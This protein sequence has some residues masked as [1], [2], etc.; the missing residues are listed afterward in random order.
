MSKKK[1]ELKYFGTAL[2]CARRHVAK[3]S[4]R[5]LEQ[6]FGISRKQIRKIERGCHMPSPEFL[7][8]IFAAGLSKLAGKQD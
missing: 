5:E 4:F 6:I 3:I 2:W 7:T 1:V 8:R